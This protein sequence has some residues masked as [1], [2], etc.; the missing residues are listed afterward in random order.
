MM[1]EAGYNLTI[2]GCA[3]DSGTLTADTEMVRLSHCGSFVLDTRCS[4]VQVQYSTVQYSY[5]C[6]T[7]YGCV[8]VCDNVDGC[9]PA[10]GLH[11]S[12]GLGSL[13]IM[14]L[15]LGYYSNMASL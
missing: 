5:I 7:I 4:T 13:V 12:L 15:L 6:R 10:P 8:E 2:R 14:A 11:S 9:N 3:V 1:T